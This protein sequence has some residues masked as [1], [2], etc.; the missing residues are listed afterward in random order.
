ML[1]NGGNQTAEEI[2]AK[3]AQERELKEAQAGDL[4]RKNPSRS[5]EEI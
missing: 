1:G 4:T 5:N 3:E 2:T